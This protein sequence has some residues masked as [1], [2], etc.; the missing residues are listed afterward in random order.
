MR[1]NA[2]TALFDD[3][4]VAAAVFDCIGAL[5]RQWHVQLPASKLRVRIS[6]GGRR[7]RLHWRALMLAAYANGIFGIADAP[8]RWSV[9]SST[10]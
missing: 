9:K 8:Q 7:R 6:A 4:R 3:C 1:F 5:N 10:S 2:V